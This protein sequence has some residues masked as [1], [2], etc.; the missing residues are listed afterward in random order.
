MNGKVSEIRTTQGERNA[1]HSESVAV[2]SLI[3]L[4]V[5]KNCLLG[6]KYKINCV[7][8]GSG[9]WKLDK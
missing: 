7:I 4:L 2:F 3:T 1:S 8:S 9:F 6:S 5:Q